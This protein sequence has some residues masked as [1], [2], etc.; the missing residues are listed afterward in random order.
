ML[1]IF[2]FLKLMKYNVRLVIKIFELPVFTSL[3]TT[4][5]TGLKKPVT[6]VVLSDVKKKLKMYTEE[7]TL[8]GNMNII[9]IYMYEI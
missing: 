6:E 2:F 1:P 5:V 7:S 3:S 9:N 8:L 4:S